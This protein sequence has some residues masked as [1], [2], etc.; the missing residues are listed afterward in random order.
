M[1]TGND[2]DFSVVNGSNIFLTTETLF[3]EL[4]DIHHAAEGE[5]VEDVNC[6]A[7]IPS[8][9]TTSAEKGSVII[10]KKKKGKRGFNFSKKCFNY[11][12]LFV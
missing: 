3:P 2:I 8:N 1:A 7:R 4:Q 6:N 12:R 10:K 5:I 11:F 9:Q